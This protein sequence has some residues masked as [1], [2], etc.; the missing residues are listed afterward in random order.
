M[1]VSSSQK[2]TQLRTLTRYD[3]TL[4]IEQ[5]IRK[6]Q[7]ALTHGAIHRLS[8]R[9]YIEYAK[10]IIVDSAQDLERIIQWLSL[11]R[12]T[13]NDLYPNSRLTP[14][15]EKIFE[16]C[17]MTQS[18]E[19]NT[20]LVL[21]LDICMDKPNPEDTTPHLNNLKALLNLLGFSFYKCVQ[22]LEKF[23]PMLMRIT[24][25]YIRQQNDT[26][27]SLPLNTIQSDYPI[28][29]K[30]PQWTAAL[31]KYLRITSRQITRQNKVYFNSLVCGIT[32]TIIDHYNI[33]NPQIWHEISYLLRECLLLGQTNILH[34]VFNKIELS[35]EQVF[36]HE[37][38]EYIKIAS[39]LNSFDFLNR[40]FLETQK[41][42]FNDPNDINNL[43]HLYCILLSTN[44][45]YFRKK[46][47]LALPNKDFRELFEYNPIVTT[48]FWILAVQ[49]QI[50]SIQSPA[51]TDFQEL[52]LL[53]ID[54]IFQNSPETTLDFIRCSKNTKNSH[55]ITARIKKT[56]QHL[57]TQA[58]MNKQTDIEK[59]LKDLL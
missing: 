2:L 43:L 33:N 16:I 9:T 53:N 44:R 46:I 41:I 12:H 38:L 58:N 24:P 57:I 45:P 29:D 30:S 49:K 25:T 13:N 36:S 40:A 51:S 37:F 1:N 19:W 6:L 10:E 54:Y 55:P 28:I 11:V 34:A 22:Y 26:F 17:A 42:S 59:R 32:S 18:T 8:M 50:I 52:V 15:T 48:K 20:I 3:N 35:H 31:L 39:S 5:Q 27:L 21:W 7:L 47:D 4:I 14:L 23:H 56:I